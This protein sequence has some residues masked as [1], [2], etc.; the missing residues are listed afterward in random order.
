M[1]GPWPV[2]VAVVSPLVAVAGGCFA[3]ACRVLWLVLWRWVVG[4]RPRARR[5]GA[6]SRT[7]TRVV[8]RGVWCRPARRVAPQGAQAR[9]VARLAWCRCRRVEG[10]V[11]VVVA[12]AVYAWAVC[13]VAWVAV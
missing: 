11:V 1:V 2:E 8:A 9:V 3:V 5:V 7:G 6:Y 10:V 13:G 12:W 4:W